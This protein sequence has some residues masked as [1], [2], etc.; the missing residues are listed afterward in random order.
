MIDNE[1]A[2]GLRP[3]TVVKHVDMDEPTRKFAIDLATEAIEKFKIEKDIAA[4]IKKEFDKR[5]EPTW[6]CV[7]GRNFGSYVT[8][9]KHSFIY[10]YVGNMAVLLFKNG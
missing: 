4:Y 1:I 2:T 10:F 3:E 6:H 8:H 9:E 7:V 5:F